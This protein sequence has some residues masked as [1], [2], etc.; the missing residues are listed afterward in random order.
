MSA[1]LIA[2]SPALERLRNEGY[3][4]EVRN[5]AQ[6]VFLLV[7]D[8]PYVN[9]LCEVKRGTLM[10]PLELVADAAAAPVGNHQCWFIGEHP[11]N[12][13]GTEITEIKH[14]SIDQDHGGGIV[15]N[16][17]FSAKRPDG[18][19][20]PDYHAKMKTY[21]DI[22]SATAQ[23][24]QPDI[25]AKVYKP[26]ADEVNSSVFKYADSAS[27]RAGI[28]AASGKLAVPKIAIIGLGG[29]GS[30]VLDLVAKT[31]VREIHLFDDDIFHQ[32]NAFR[33][34]GAPGIEEFHGQKKVAYFAGIYSKMRYGVIPHEYKVAVENAG[35]LAGMD[36]VFVCVDKP[37]AR[38]V[39]TDALRA[40]SI[41]FIDVGMGVQM[42]QGSALYGQCRTTLIT[43]YKHDHIDDNISFG[44]GPGN[45]LYASDIQVADL[46]ALNATLAVIKWKKCSGFYLDDAKEYHSV[47]TVGLH[48]LS[49]EHRE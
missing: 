24:I 11:C 9:A 27:S 26:Y 6:G 46:N 30:Y 42:T 10:S 13:D 20:Y 33:A 25:T 32:H 37:S 2:R 44:D 17:G 4:V 8:V 22:L 16:H 29:T 41:H 23:H 3:S 7:H 35:E 43:P 39:I 5:G 45:D 15:V 1:T 12:H 19:P 49:K 38:H 40:L 18:V 47:Y 21:V 14:S 28:G 34:P 36:F 48:T 31:H